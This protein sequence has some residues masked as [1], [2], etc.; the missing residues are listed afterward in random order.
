[1]EK[2]TA[3]E[4]PQGLPPQTQARVEWA[5]LLGWLRLLRLPPTDPAWAAVRGRLR[6]PSSPP[7]EGWEAWVTELRSSRAALAKASVDRAV[8]ELRAVG[9]RLTQARDWFARRPP[10]EVAL[11]GDLRAARDSLDA[12]EAALRQA[13]GTPPTAAS[14]GVAVHRLL[15]ALGQARDVAR[16]HQ[17]LRDLFAQALGGAR[18]AVAAA[19][20]AAD[21]AAGAARSLA[22]WGV[23]AGVALLAAWLWKR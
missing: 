4:T 6:F 11:S 22:P 5:A 20:T 13:E 16:D 1:M 12:A 7:P 19:A 18:A 2:L 9:E 10:S 21:Q 14:W 15:D 23:V 17:D 8:L 3:Q